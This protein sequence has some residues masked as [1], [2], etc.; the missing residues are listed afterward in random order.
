[1]GE[2]S[3][4]RKCL[5]SLGH[6]CRACRA[7]P[8]LLGRRDRSEVGLP[9]FVRDNSNFFDQVPLH[10]WQCSVC[11]LVHNGVVKDSWEGDRVH[12]WQ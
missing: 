9:P 10:S 6:M 11:S 2:D 3:G 8:L 12:C 4:I 5:A 1:M 7:E